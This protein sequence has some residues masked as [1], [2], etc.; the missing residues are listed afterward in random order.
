MSQWIFEGLF[1]G[2]YFKIYIIL[3]YSV[4]FAAHEIQNAF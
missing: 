1:H 4:K 2:L 3:L